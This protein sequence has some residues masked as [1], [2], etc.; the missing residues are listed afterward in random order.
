MKQELYY[1]QNVG[2]GYIGNSPI[3]WA[4]DGHGYTQWLDD[5]EK[6]TA[7]EAKKIIASTRGSHKWKRWPVSKIDAISQRTVDIQK[8]RRT[9]DTMS[10]DKP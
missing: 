2:A 10:P 1:L 7:E 8:M 6:M 5:A 3:F 9:T 4:K